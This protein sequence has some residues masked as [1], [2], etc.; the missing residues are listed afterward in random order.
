MNRSTIIKTPLNIRH[1]VS[2]VICLALG[3]ALLFAG[4]IKGMDLGSFIKQINQYGL[5]PSNPHLIGSL[6]WLV[7]TV[8]IVIGTALVINWR[9]KATL[10]C[11]MVLFTIFL[12]AL[13]W[14]I[15]KGGVD[16]C[17]CFG[18]AATRSP[19]QALIED[20][21]LFFAAICA[22][23]MG[24][25]KPYSRHAAKAGLVV[26]ASLT[27]L[28]LPAITGGSLP[29]NQ[30]T[31]APAAVSIFRDLE[32]QAPTGDT[33]DFNHRTVLLALMSTDCN[34]CRESVPLLNELVE[35]VGQDIQIFG[36]AANDQAEIDQFIEENFAFYPVVRTDEKNLTALLGDSPLPKLLLIK[37]GNIIAQWTDR[38][39]SPQ[40]LSNLTEV[41]GA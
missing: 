14:A 36:L 20:F 29:W 30:T 25:D 41:K 23:R 18:P 21:V 22:L 37:K 13:A 9:P 28:V 38:L 19:T 6:A 39:P 15:I 33:I 17:G 40:D 35:E 8:E 31:S 32:L 3:A 12:G 5:M 10:S 27:G 2:R 24:F 1:L 11:T 7:V 16:D 4:V 34:H 26:F